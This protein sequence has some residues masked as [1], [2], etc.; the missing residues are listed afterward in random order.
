M[1]SVKEK[2]IKVTL[3]RSLIGTKKTHRATVRGLGLRRINSSVELENT[4]SVQGM[5]NK[6]CYLV[7]CDT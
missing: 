6:I 3:I 7:K 1:M 2:R 4:P 5:I